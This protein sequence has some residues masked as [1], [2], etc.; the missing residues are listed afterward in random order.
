MQL[1]NMMK[2]IKNLRRKNSFSF[3]MIMIVA[4]F[5]CEKNASD[6]LVYKESIEN[7]NYYIIEKTFEFD[8]IRYVKSFYC[9][10]D[11]IFF[12]RYIKYRITRDT[13]FRCKSR[14]DNFGIPYLI[15][16]NEVVCHTCNMPLNIACQTIYK[17]SVIV[18][19]K[20]FLKFY[21]Q[22]DV[23]DGFSGWIYCD[24]NYKI[25]KIEPEDTSD[26]DLCRVLI[27]TIPASLMKVV[28]SIRYNVDSF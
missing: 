10:D 7:R 13:L 19:D 8:D 28:D 18:N 23:Y 1:N 9:D 2:N 20:R 3:V 6:V 11:S 5:S 17:G 4:F 14:T 12:K 25:Y 27:D 21:L 26:N 22:E 15:K 24:V 16:N